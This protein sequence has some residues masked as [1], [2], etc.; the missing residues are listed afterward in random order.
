MVGIPGF[1]S[2]V[3]M[4]MHA[5][6]DIG[7]ILSVSICPM[8]ILCQNE[9]IYRHTFFSFGSGIILVFSSPM[10]RRYKIPK[11]TPSAE[12]SNARWWEIFAM[13]SIISELVRDRAILISL[14]WNTNKEV[15]GSR[16]IH[17]GSMILSDLERADLHNYA[18]VVWP[19]MTEFG[20]VT[21][22]GEKYIYRVR[23]SH[24]HISR[25]G[26]AASQKNLG[27]LPTPKRLDL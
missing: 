20:V 5:E 16:S 11:R 10:H 17:V 2:R 21:Q 24:A 19:R 12:G 26:A 14:L 13:S 7:I 3:S 8:S 23:V 25:G 22:A 6:R 9:W 15:I 4:N 18:R 1:L 27:P